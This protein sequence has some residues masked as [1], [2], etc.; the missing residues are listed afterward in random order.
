ML[1]ELL[2]DLYTFVGET[3]E[4]VFELS[5]QIGKLLKGKDPY[6]IEDRLFEI[7]RAV[8]GNYTMK[9]AFDMALYDLQ[10]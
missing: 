4:T 7:E 10:G 3:Q 9:S 8:K 6:A 2:A 1:S 5:L